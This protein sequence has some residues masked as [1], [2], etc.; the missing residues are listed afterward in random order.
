[1]SERDHSQ[2]E[3]D[4]SIETRPSETSKS[5]H[6]SEQYEASSKGGSK[7]TANKK[8][9][10]VDW[11]P[12]LHRRFVQAVEQL[13]VEKAI[14]SRILELMG[15]KSLTRHN[16]ASHLQKYRSHRRHL[17]AREADA[18]NWNSRKPAESVWPGNVAPGTWQYPGSASGAQA[19]PPP[20]QPHPVFGVPQT[21]Q[22]PHMAQPSA[23][24]VGMP[25]H[26]WGHPAM[27]HSRAHMWQQP[28]Q[29]APAYPPPAWFAPDGSVWHYG[30]MQAPSTPVDA[31]GH[32]T[33]PVPGPPCFPRHQATQQQPFVPGVSYPMGP[34]VVSGAPVYA[35]RSMAENR[36]S[37]SLAQSPETIGAFQDAA[38]VVADEAM[39]NTMFAV[40][41]DLTLDFTA[42]SNCLNDDLNDANDILDAAITEALTNPTAPLPL[43]LKPPS[44]D[45]V[46]NELN[47][48]GITMPLSG[49]LEPRDASV[50]VKVAAVEFQDF[51][52]H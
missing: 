34:S 20:M 6:Q 21:F 37:A 4:A 3:P 8:K 46:L 42:I 26:M 19:Q 5:T 24:A 48:Q 40:S 16:I 15:V 39:P 7:S 29:Q 28:P 12:E 38:E 30:G 43:G 44:L 23:P 35:P 41:D 33:M 22:Y 10:K 2:L 18:A 14:P 17:A 9:A 36:A 11:T 13:G 27:G 31:W 1:M 50:E 49:C 51:L 32:P 45:G 52:K 25:M 47:K